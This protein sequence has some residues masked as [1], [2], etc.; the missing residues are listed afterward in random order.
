MSS[1][2]DDGLALEVQKII[3]VTNTLLE[4]SR[5]NELHDAIITLELA[6]NETPENTAI[7][8]VLIRAHDRLGHHEDALQF[9][10]ALMG[11]IMKKHKHVDEL[12]KQ[13]DA[14]KTLSEVL[15]HIL[16]PKTHKNSDVSFKVASACES[17]S[18]LAESR[19]KALDNLLTLKEA[20]IL[21]QFPQYAGYVCIKAA[22]LFCD[23]DQ[24]DLA[25]DL[26]VEAV[27]DLDPHNERLYL[28]V[29]ENFRERKRVGDLCKL[30]FKKHE[31][32][33]FNYEQAS[34]SIIEIMSQVIQ[35]Q[36]QTIK[37]LEEKVELLQSTIIDVTQKTIPLQQVQLNELTNEVQELRMQIGV[38]DKPL[39]M[40]EE[41]MIH[42]DEY[43]DSVRER[44][45]LNLIP[46]AVTSSIETLDTIFCIVWLDDS[47]VAVSFTRLGCIQVWNISTCELV[48]TFGK[49]LDHM[50]NMWELACIDD[51][52]LLICAT[53]EAA[54][55]KIFNWQTGEVVNE[56][57][58]SAPLSSYGHKNLIPF[59]P[60]KK[61]LMIGLQNKNLAIYDFRVKGGKLVKELG[62]H[63]DWV[64]CCETLP[65]GLVATGT[66]N[67]INIWNVE[68]GLMENTI[69]AHVGYVTSL[70]L[71]DRDTLVSG[72]EDNYIKVWDLKN[73]I[74]L[75]ELS[76][77]NDAVVQVSLLSSNLLVS[78][79]EDGCIIVY[80][81]QDG[82]E[83]KVLSDHSKAVFTVA[84]NNKQLVSGSADK[85]IH[86][87]SLG[88]EYIS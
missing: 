19:S 74:C 75:H 81:I 38:G 25:C 2:S 10:V 3:K 5:N 57:T 80:N 23:D 53:F 24:Q 28:H 31:Q 79:S 43:V 60:S 30:V 73:N 41:Y 9:L 8:K 18:H 44:A 59:G 42:C 34:Q 84:F 65:N 13:R 49:D 33:S 46:G 22:E 72:G 69:H 45:D 17:F 26:M 63:K 14:I 15:H 32:I 55:V 88:N 66:S 71:V 76:G 58:T 78:C 61:Y 6:Q 70:A 82:E 50:I 77:H 39:T 37:S 48:R 67:L 62:P 21:S 1:P 83:V 12:H 86:V 52:N 11:V 16:N 27:N 68:T 40:S 51:E 47:L 64:Y 85:Y 36:Q 7:L 29:V 54:S 35:S 87:S 56:I 20:L 4:E